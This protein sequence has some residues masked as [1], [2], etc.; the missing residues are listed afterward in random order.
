MYV[1]MYVF[2][3]PKTFKILALPKTFILYIIIY[4]AVVSLF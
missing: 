1:C 3:S 2:Y 4:R